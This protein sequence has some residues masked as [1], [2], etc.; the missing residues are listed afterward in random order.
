MGI[1]SALGGATYA[2]EQ[3]VQGKEI[4]TGGLIASTIAG[5]IG[6]AFGGKG[7][8]AKGLNAAWKGVQKG[9]TRELRRANVKYATK[10]IARYTADKFI[11]KNTVKVGAAR[12]TGGE[13]TYTGL[14]LK[15][16]IR[17]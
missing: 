14:R 3:A 15:W 12:F 4:T 13:I 2:A 6:G 1:N 10:Q 5:G 7:L 9:I 8:N 11:I 16:G 17:L